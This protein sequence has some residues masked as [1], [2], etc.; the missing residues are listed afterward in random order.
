M[1]VL[2]PWLT[3]AFK[4]FIILKYVL[5]PSV[6]RLCLAMMLQQELFSLPL[7]ARLYSLASYTP[8]LY[9]SSN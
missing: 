7:K 4:G 1:R 6:T 8:F 3:V 9:F 5:H 2:K